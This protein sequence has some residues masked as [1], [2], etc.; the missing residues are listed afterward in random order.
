MRKYER[1]PIVVDAVQ[2]TGGAESAAEVIAAAGLG[3]S[4]YLKLADEAEAVS[5]ATLAGAVLMRPGQWLVPIGRW[6]TDGVEL[7]A[8]WAILS[9][10]EFQANYRPAGTGDEACDFGKAFAAVRN[11]GKARRDAWADGMSIYWEPHWSPGKDAK[12]SQPMFALTLV[13]GSVVPWR[14]SDTDFS[15]TDWRVFG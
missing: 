2:F 15:A 1:I 13:D 11:G 8:D 3:D 4:A 9:D 7:K 5:V 6:V 14:P 12:A 10:A